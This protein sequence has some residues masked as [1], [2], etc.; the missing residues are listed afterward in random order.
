[1]SINPKGDLIAMQSTLIESTFS[2]KK[3]GLLM[4]YH[5]PFHN[6]GKDGAYLIPPFFILFFFNRIF[7]LIRAI[8][9]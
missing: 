6:N 7:A 2:I 3:K 9:L 8:Q 5:V 1:M 4:L